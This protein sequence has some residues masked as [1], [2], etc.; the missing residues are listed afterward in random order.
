MTIKFEQ[1]WPIHLDYIPCSD[2]A[3]FRYGEFKSIY[4]KLESNIKPYVDDAIINFLDLINFK[5][6]TTKSPI[7]LVLFLSMATI[8]FQRKLCKFMQCYYTRIEPQYEVFVDD[9]PKY[10]LDFAIYAS[11]AVTDKYKFAIECDG[12][13]FHQKTKDQVEK[14]KQRERFL[15]QNGWTV[16]RFTGTEILSNPTKCTDEI[17]KIIE[18]TVKT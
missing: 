1:D 12:H 17:L 14:D 16:I 13:E 10:R 18:A 3:D 15:Q 2:N 6:T 5:V 9:K 11:D 7:E 8:P 4:D